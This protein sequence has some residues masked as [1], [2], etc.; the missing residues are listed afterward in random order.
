MVKTKAEQLIGIAKVLELTGISSVTAWRRYTAI[1]PTFPAPAGFVLGSRRWRLAEIEAW[2]AAQLARK[3]KP[4]NL[5]RGA[6]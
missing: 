4:G 1:P 5:A 6:R 3:P 2:L